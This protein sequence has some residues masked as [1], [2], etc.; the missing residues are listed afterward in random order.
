MATLTEKLKR[1]IVLAVTSE[2]YGKELIDAI[3]HADAGGGAIVDSGRATLVAGDAT[4]FSTKITSTSRVMLTASG[5]PLSGKLHYDTV[6]EGVSFNIHT[7]NGSDTHD[8]DW[9]IVN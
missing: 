1:R 9:I 3:E 6:V 5:F 2:K 7:G 4:I 8:V